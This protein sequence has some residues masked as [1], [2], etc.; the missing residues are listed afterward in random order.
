[1]IP[2][3]RSRI[4]I[5][6]YGFM[7]GPDTDAHGFYTVHH[8]T[9]VVLA[10]YDIVDLDLNWSEGGNTIFG[11]SIDGPTEQ[12]TVEIE[13]AIDPDLF[14]RFECADIEVLRVKPLA[15][16]VHPHWTDAD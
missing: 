7:S 10:F 14:V 5:A 11:M 1:M 3:G 13:S 12:R 15:D 8:R 6:L 16:N 9:T 4:R 2:P